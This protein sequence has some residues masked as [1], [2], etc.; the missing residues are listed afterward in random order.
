MFGEGYNLPSFFEDKTISFEGY[1]FHALKDDSFI[2]F[3]AFKRF[4]AMPI[5]FS[6]TVLYFVVSWAA[7]CFVCGCVGVCAFAERRLCVC[8][9]SLRHRRSCRGGGRQ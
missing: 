6:C 4:V 7:P 1:N 2:P 5:L 3:A 8:A 9:Q